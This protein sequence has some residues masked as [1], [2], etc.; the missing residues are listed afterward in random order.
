MDINTERCVAEG[1]IDGCST[2]MGAL[3]HWHHLHF[4]HCS[5]PCLPLP[6]QPAA[7]HIRL[8]AHVRTRTLPA[9]AH[10]PCT[11][12]PTC[13]SVIAASH[14]SRCSAVS[15]PATEMTEASAVLAILLLPAP[16]PA[17]HEARL[18]AWTSQRQKCRERAVLAAARGVGRA[19]GGGWSDWRVCGKDEC[20]GSAIE[21]CILA[22][23]NAVVHSGRGG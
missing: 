8:Y 4:L 6:L 7:V 10:T 13:T 17:M 23:S 15:S 1:R 5:E 12:A 21:R 18:H 11:Q 2:G 14:A 9:H 16:A 3:T 20:A 22:K 19:R